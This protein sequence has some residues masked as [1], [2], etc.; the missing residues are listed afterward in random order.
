VKEDVPSYNLQTV[1]IIREKVVIFIGNWF[2]ILHKDLKMQCICQ[3][4]LLRML[5]KNLQ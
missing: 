2:S 1:E 4:I 5:T 3:Y